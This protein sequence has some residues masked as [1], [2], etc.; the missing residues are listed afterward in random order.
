MDDPQTTPSIDLKGR[1]ILAVDD[2]RINLRI[3]GGIL[4]HEGYEIAEAA[5]GE[6]ALETYASFQPNLVLLDVMMP[7][8]TG[9]PPAG[10]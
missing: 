6:Q 10:P 5:S 2:D 9:S 4:R 7:G 1:R 3:I 8:S